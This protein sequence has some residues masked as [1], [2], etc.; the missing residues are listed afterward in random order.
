MVTLVPMTAESVVKDLWKKLK[1]PKRKQ[2]VKQFLRD[3]RD[4]KVATTKRECLAA[5]KRKF[6][7]DIDWSVILPLIIQYL[8]LLL[9]LLGK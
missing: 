8:P 5:A 9:S 7:L 1:S 2:E 4:G 6:G 3:V